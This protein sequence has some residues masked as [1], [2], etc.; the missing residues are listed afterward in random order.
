MDKAKINSFIKRGNEI[1]ENDKRQRVIDSKNGFCS[2]A[3]IGG[4][5]YAQ[6]MSEIK[7]FIEREVK[8]HPLYK[9]MNDA[10]FFRDSKDSAFCDIMGCLQTLLNENFEYE[11]T[12]NLPKKQSIHKNKAIGGVEM[13]SNEFIK[14]MLD[15]CSQLKEQ[16][17][18]NQIWNL[19]D[20]VNAPEHIE[21]TSSEFRK[22][23]NDID[24][25]FSL[26]P[27]DEQQEAN[28]LLAQPNINFDW[29]DDMEVLLHS[30]A[31]K[32]LVQAP[33]IVTPNT[34][35]STGKVF[36]VHGHDNEAKIETA[37]VVEKLGLKA[38][39]LHEQASAG[40]TIIEK[41]GRC[42]DVGFAIVL[43]TPC[44]EGHSKQETKPQ[45]RAR[46]N[47]V[48][49][50]GYLIGKLGRN[51]VCAL[52]KGDVETPG[53]ISG[54]VYIPMDNAGAWKYSLVDEM[55]AAGFKLN[56]NDI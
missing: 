52:V 10:Y 27:S 44:D 2:A 32:M 25:Y 8:T 24:T 35:L 9:T 15:T 26:F 6:W 23:K 46:Q 22:F 33:T 20:G 3:P 53:D 40:D 36:I 11:E 49:E 21:R 4:R 29:L 43:Y 16:I 45:N 51:R 48:F 5:E 13:N 30:L 54:V 42:S 19:N 47:V 31:N 28:A 17:N 12:V 34:K 14:K 56:K 37:R 39:I 41:I 55:N 38:V 7:V 50:H 18:T 1:E